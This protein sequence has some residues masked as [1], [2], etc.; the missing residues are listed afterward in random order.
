M[1]KK[2]TGSTI[3]REAIKAVVGED[4]YRSLL[5]YADKRKDG[6]RRVK[7][8][9]VSWSHLTKVEVQEV[10]DYIVAHYGEDVEVQEG[11]SGSRMLEYVAWVL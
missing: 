7:V 1:E 10:T 2:I 3:V 11:R 8:Q 6:K 4:R 9:Q 5:I